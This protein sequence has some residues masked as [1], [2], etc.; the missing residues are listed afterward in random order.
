[1]S[2]YHK[3]QGWEHA[4]GN[5][6]RFRG[7]TDRLWFAFN[8]TEIKA[9]NELSFTADDICE[10]FGTKKTTVSSKAGLIQK[11]GNIYLGD[12]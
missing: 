11:T 12:T 6:D 2:S 8:P 3:C 9:G 10:F 1:M 7:D 4:P 5:T